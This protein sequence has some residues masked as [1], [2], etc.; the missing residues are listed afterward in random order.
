MNATRRP[1]L[2]AGVAVP[3]L[4]FGS[5]LAASALYPGYNHLTQYASELGMADRPH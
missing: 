1:L 5:M 4:Y 3:I 2:L